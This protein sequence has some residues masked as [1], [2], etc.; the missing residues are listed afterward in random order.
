M[1]VNSKVLNSKTYKADKNSKVPAILA[2]TTKNLYFLPVTKNATTAY[3]QVNANMQ[4]ILAQAGKKQSWNNAI[5]TGKTKLD[6][7]WKQ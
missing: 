2:D 7:A 1:P 4:T 6:L 3:D 5:S